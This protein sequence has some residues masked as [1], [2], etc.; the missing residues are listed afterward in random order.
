[1]KKP[2]IV[3]V[4][5]GVLA[6]VGISEFVK[7]DKMGEVDKVNENSFKSEDG[8][9]V[10]Y[11]AGGCFWGTEKLFS[12]IPGVTDAVSGYAN[13]DAGVVPSYGNIGETNFKETVRVE[14]NPKEVS[15]DVLLYAYFSVIDPTVKNRQGNDVGSQYQTGIYYA[16]EE[17]GK[18]VGEAAE[19]EKLKYDKFYVEILPL[20]NFYGAEEYHQNYLEKNP[21]GYCHI[22]NKEM[23]EVLKNI[24]EKKIG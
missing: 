14:Y 1:M 17:S 6:A 4:I 20:E 3:L 8:K 23:D 18:A 7:K 12:E 21:T 15:L 5:V 16:D 9:S 24:K 2:I 11:F 22:S 13:G 10:I 19:K